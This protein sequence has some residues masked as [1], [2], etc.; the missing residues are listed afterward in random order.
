MQVW[1]LGRR[2]ELGLQFW[3]LFSAP[4]TPGFQPHFPSS[5]MTMAMQPVS[6]QIRVQTPEEAET[7]NMWLRGRPATGW[8][9]A[10][11]TAGP[12]LLIN[13]ASGPKAGRLLG[14]LP[15]LLVDPLQGWKSGFVSLERG[16][17]GRQIPVSGFWP[18]IKSVQRFI[19]CL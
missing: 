3:A 8:G 19:C 7:V 15:C 16:R 13:T 17:Y 9:G 10:H 18:Q 5:A 4:S 2:S 12:S 1:S 6:G 14:T 11:R